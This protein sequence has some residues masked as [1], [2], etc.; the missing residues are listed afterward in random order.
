MKARRIVSAASLVLALSLATVA[1]AAVKNWTDGTGNWI[2]GANWSGGTVPMAGDQV[3]IVFTDGVA[4][5]VTYDVTAP[6]LGALTIDLTG[7]GATTNTLSIAA[8]NLTA[9]GL[10]TVGNSGRGSVN[11]TGGTTTISG[12]N[13]LFLGN[14]AGSVGS[15][16]L[17]NT[18][19]LAVTGNENIGLSGTG[20]F[21]QSAGSNTLTLDMVMGFTSAALG[22]YTMSGGTFSTG[23]SQYIGY[24][25]TGSGGQSGGTFN[26][27]GGT[28]TVASNVYLGY[29]AGSTGTYA[30]SG[31]TL[32]VGN[33]LVVGNSGT[34]TLTIE[35]NASAYVTNNLLIDSLST[36]NL[37]GGTLRIFMA[38]GINRLNYTAGT[39]QL[40]FSRDLL[41]D[42]TITTLFGANPTIPSGKGLT[43]EG[44]ALI[45]QLS[46][47][48][49][50]RVSG[51]S[52][53]VSDELR[54]YDAYLE[55]TDGGI[56]TSAEGSFGAASNSTA[57]VTV[58]GPGSTW[59]VINDKLVVGGFGDG[60]VLNIRDGALVDI[61]TTLIISDKGVVNLDGGTIRFDGYSRSGTGIFNF[62]A[63]T[64]QLP[65]NR[66]IGSD[67][68]IADIVGGAPTLTTGKGLT[69]EG[70][71]TL[72][73]TTP[74]TM[75]GG[76]ISAPTVILPPGGRINSTQTSV[77]NGP[78]LALAGS[79]F[80]IASG[81]LSMGDIQK[82]NGF[83]SNGTTSVG[84]GAVSLADANDAVFDSAALVT[85]GAGGNPGTLNAFNGLTLDFGGNITGFGT[86][87]TPNN[88]AKPLINNGHITG[89]SAAQRITLPGYVKGVGTFDNVNFTGTFSP[90]FSPASLNVGNIAFSPTSTLIIE[91]GGTTPGSQYDQINVAGELTLGGTLELSLIN[92]FVPSAGQTFDILNWG[93]LAGV[94]SD[95]Q[96]PPLEGLA[97]NT[98]Q[99][100][101]GM[102]S[103]ALPGDIDLDG[104]VDGTDAAVFARHFGAATGSEWTTGDFN[105]DGATTLAD[106][107]ILQSHFGE[108]LAMASPAL[109]Q[110]VPEPS[111]W[112]LGLLG[113]W[114]CGTDWIGRRAGRGV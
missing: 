34:G 26:Q 97:W 113:V 1:T 4:R 42:T 99:L 88:L 73:A 55:I 22:T 83:Y 63:G 7:A 31:G 50:V 46:T 86:L 76:T 53:A 70:T 6:N 8:N 48:Q 37:N 102:L 104:D 84:S 11:Q 18:G 5:T 2:V 77:I 64:I 65:G 92:G 67:S 110:P 15:Y 103:V 40:A 35:N 29:N 100:A 105:D 9:S 62:N 91:I 59:N 114:L 93:T 30:L 87:S 72:S 85:L 94:F 10:V 44:F 41:T 19:S 96:L 32:T 61:G 3:N 23:G 74:L 79:V 60:A 82:V 112:A 58:S 111:T 28:N 68:A 24:S 95:I 107:A 56:V 71:A 106:L 14:N 52:L 75:A 81:S 98:S 47:T 27:S 66:S 80:E 78:I 49:I 36:V 16:S 89:K 25:A 69:V 13:S 90:G 39:I 51:G 33:D 109:H 38:S 20:S 21:T 43:V 108:R 17:S 101:T 57:T 12:S 54:L 45:G